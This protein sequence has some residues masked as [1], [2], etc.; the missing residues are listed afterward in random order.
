MKGGMRAKAFP[1]SNLINRD[2]TYEARMTTILLTKKKLCPGEAPSYIPLWTR[3]KT[4]SMAA[5][6]SGLW[7]G[8]RELGKRL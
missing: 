1:N 4:P 7:K 8:P 3:H 2:V 5:K 6:I